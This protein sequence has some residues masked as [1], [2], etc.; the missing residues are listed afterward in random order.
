GRAGRAGAPR[1]QLE[2]RTQSPNHKPNPKQQT[3][4]TPQT[5]QKIKIT[6]HYTFN[7]LPSQKQKLLKPNSLEK[8]AD[9]V[10]IKEEG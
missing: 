10:T 6:T 1:E 7:K 5:Q 3:E 4:Q 9:S 2:K 8:Y